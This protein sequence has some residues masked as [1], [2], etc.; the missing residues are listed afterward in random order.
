[1]KAKRWLTGGV[2]SLV[3]AFSFAALYKPEK[4]EVRGTL[5]EVGSLSNELKEIGLRKADGSVVKFNVASL[6]LVSG[7]NIDVSSRTAI[8]RAE[9][10]E[11]LLD[12]IENAVLPRSV[13]FG[14]WQYKA[15]TF[16]L[17][18]QTKDAITSM[19]GMDHSSMPGMDH[20]SMPGMDMSKP[21]PP[22][23]NHH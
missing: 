5:D 8:Y 21:M 20:D 12:K 6:G 22:E 4:I 19:P 9:S 7:G 3:A 18:P 10:Q 2:L 14:D 23:H 17:A 11:S 16:G 13:D 1:M 15:S